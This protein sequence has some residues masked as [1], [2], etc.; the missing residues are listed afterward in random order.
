MRIGSVSM[1]DHASKKALPIPSS[2]DTGFGE[3]EFVAVNR[4]RSSALRAAISAYS[5]PSSAGS[6]LIL[7]CSFGSPMAVFPVFAVIASLLTFT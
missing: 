2:S 3:P 5:R 4:A 7:S 6:N 1:R